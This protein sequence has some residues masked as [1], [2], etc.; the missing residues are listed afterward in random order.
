MG[1]RGMEHLRELIKEIGLIRKTRR[2]IAKEK[3]IEEK[4]D[5]PIPIADNSSGINREIDPRP[6]I[7]PPM[8][9]RKP[10][11]PPK[12]HPWKKDIKKKTYP[13]LHSDVFQQSEQELISNILK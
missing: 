9:P 3:I 1:K 2:H 10:H 12:G 13:D 4:L 6:I 8:K 11:A 5:T 7:R